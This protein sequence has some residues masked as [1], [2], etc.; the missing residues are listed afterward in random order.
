MTSSDRRYLVH[1]G[2]LH[3]SLE[4]ICPDPSLRQSH[5]MCQCM[6]PVIDP[7]P[8]SDETLPEPKHIEYGFALRRPSPDRRK[9]SST[10]QLKDQLR[11]PAIVLMTRCGSFPYQNRIADKK[12]MTCF[13]EQLLEPCGPG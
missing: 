7:G 3:Q 4:S 2:R 13:K 11:I 5:V 8:L 10:Q 1:L 6:Q 12:L 9:L